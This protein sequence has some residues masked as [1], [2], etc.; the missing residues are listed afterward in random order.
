MD[1]SFIYDDIIKER[2]CAKLDGF[3]LITCKSKNVLTNIQ[4]KEEE[5]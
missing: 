4:L 2:K 5:L 1:S 3:A